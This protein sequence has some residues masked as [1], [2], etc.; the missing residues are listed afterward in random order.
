[1]GKPYEGPLPRHAK[2]YTNLFE[3]ARKGFATFK[4]EVAS[5]EFPSVDH[6]IKADPSVVDAFRATVDAAR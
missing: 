2:R 6:L 1:M 4:A 3:E 5:G